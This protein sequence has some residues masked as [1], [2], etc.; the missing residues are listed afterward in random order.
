MRADTDA[1]DVPGEDWRSKAEAKGERHRRAAVDQHDERLVLGE[2]ARA[3]I[4][5]LGFLCEQIG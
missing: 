2:V 3:R 1:E 5:S 4:E